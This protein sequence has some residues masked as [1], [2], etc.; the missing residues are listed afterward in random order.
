M[1][2]GQYCVIQLDI[3]KTIEGLLHQHNEGSHSQGTNK[4]ILLLI[5]TLWARAKEIEKLMDKEMDKL[6]EETF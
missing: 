3:Y 6:A 2:Y 4:S 1:S 5:D